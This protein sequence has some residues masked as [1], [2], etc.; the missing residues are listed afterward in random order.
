M[1]IDVADALLQLICSLIPAARTLGSGQAGLSKLRKQRLTRGILWY[2]PVHETLTFGLT[3]SSFT[4]SHLWF[5]LC[6]W[7][8]LYTPWVDFY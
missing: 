5:W 1:Q 8:E 2:E 3:L 4:G 7:Y 6:Y